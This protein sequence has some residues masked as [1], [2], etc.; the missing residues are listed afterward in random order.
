MMPQGPRSLIGA[1]IG[2]PEPETANGIRD[3]IVN[4]SEQWKRATPGREFR[5]HS[6]WEGRPLN[7]CHMAMTEIM[8]S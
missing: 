3:A 7:V 4:D 2:R 8:R 6:I 5:P 1:G